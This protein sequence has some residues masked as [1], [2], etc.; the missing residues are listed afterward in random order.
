MND[1]T[2]YAEKP[3]VLGQA[4]CVEPSMAI[5][6]RDL[7]RVAARLR[8]GWFGAFVTTGVFSEAVQSEVY[9]DQYPILLIN[10]SQV[11]REL[12][13]IMNAENISLDD[14]LAREQN[15]LLTHTEL[16]DPSRIVDQTLFGSRL[17]A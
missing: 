4:K 6:G 8:R 14:L 11:A 7:A 15:W 16:V 12:R 2:G 3:V 17:D 1:Y 5:S 10:G 9:S 13:L